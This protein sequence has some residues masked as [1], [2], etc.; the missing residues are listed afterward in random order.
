M[1]DIAL[2]RRSQEGGRRLHES[3]PLPGLRDR[4]HGRLGGRIARPARDRI[5]GFGSADREHGAG[6]EEALALVRE[7]REHLHVGTAMEAGV[8]LRLWAERPE[9]MLPRPGHALDRLVAEARRGEEGGG[10]GIQF[11]PGA[12]A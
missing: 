12:L 3:E 7:L 11:G 5:R 9:D 6:G 4:P 1:R 8:V 2:P 10:H